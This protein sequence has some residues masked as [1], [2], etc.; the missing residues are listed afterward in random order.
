MDAK[1]VQHFYT[2]S[3]PRDSFGTPTSNVICGPNVDD[4][5]KIPKKGI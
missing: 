5:M 1:K 3:T 4:N 2:G